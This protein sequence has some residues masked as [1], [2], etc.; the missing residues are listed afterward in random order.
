MTN[1]RAAYR[2]L[3]SSDWSECLA[4]CGPFD[5]IAYNYPKLESELTAV[6]RLYTGNSLSLGEALHRIGQLLPKSI[7]AEQMDAYLDTC[8]VTYPGVPQLI[9]WCLG[10]NI[11]FMINTTNSIGYF[12]RVFA[13]GLLPLVPVLSANPMIRFSETPADPPYVYELFEIEDKWKHTEKTAESF[14]IDPKKIVLIGDSGG[15]GPHFEWG[16]KT[17]AFLV[18]S[19][20]KPSLEKY[21]REKSITID[22]HIGPSH[23]AGEPSSNV[24]STQINFMALAAIIEQVVDR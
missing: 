18:G 6:F 4:P 14:G 17:G 15:D 23:A 19:M 3:V 11:L 9:E 13:K 16:M 24:S 12:Q 8:F 5:V 20:T 1:H 10:R 21:C 2:A 7:T 22:F